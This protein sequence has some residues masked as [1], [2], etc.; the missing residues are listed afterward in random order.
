MSRLIRASVLPSAARNTS[1]SQELPIANDHG[2]VAVLLSVTAVTGT[3]PT[4]TCIVEDSADGTTW[5]PVKTASAITA[6]G[7]YRIVVV[8]PADGPTQPR[9]RLRWTTGGTSP[10]FTFSVNAISRPR[11]GM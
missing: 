11:M 2:N 1:G 4:L 10:N 5:F 9:L 8:G 3:S 6:V 7:S